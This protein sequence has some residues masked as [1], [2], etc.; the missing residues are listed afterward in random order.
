M[1]SDKARVTV[2][3]T[4]L[5]AAAAE[6]LAAVCAEVAV[7]DRGRG[8]LP[9]LPSLLDGP[10]AGP[11]AG[12]LGAAAAYPGRPLLVLACDLPGVPAALLA[13]LARSTAYDWAVPRWSG[14]VEPLCALYGR[15]ALAL[16]RE[17]RLL[18]PH[19]LTE[20]RSLAVRYL[21]GDLLARF[22]PPEEIFLN[23]NTPEDL[24]RY[25]SISAGTSPHRP[26]GQISRRKSKR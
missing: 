24:E 20:E 23:L 16:L 9:G 15:A 7:A 21:E 11:A 2:G 13:E 4:S 18:A 25:T 17:R 14:G 3:G 1:G 10:G 6:R 12:I 26:Q 19:R 22:G 5:P 8:V